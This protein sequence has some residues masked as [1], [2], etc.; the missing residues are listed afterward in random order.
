VSYQAMPVGITETWLR[1][2]A[3]MT[4]PWLRLICFPHACGTAAF[5]RPWRDYLLPGVELYAVQYP[6]RLDRITDACVDDMKPMADAVAGALQPLLDRP[7]ALFGHSLGAVIAYEVA[8]RI[9]ARSPLALARLFVSGRTAPGRQRPSGKHLA[10]DDV[11]WRDIER[12]GATA[13]EVLADPEARRM[14]L[15]A[16]RSDYR[17]SELYQPGPGPLLDCPVTALLG[18]EDSEVEPEEAES[19]ADVTRAEFSI[20][21]FPGGHFYLTSR[22]PEVVGEIMCRLTDRPPPGYSDWAGP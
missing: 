17:L 4:K 14:F 21:T 9:S 18:E 3:P 13:P 15:P 12:L 22:L 8:R 5:F 1:R 16:L 10:G 20:R 19:W 6:G 7:A 2:L 11:L